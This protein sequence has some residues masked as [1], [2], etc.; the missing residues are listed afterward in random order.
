MNKNWKNKL[1]MTIKRIWKYALSA[2]LML[3]IIVAYL[4]FTRAP[5]IAKAA[6]W[7]DSWSYRKAIVIN[8]EQVTGDLTNFPVLVSL[9]DENLGNHAQD[10]GD[11]IIFISSNGQKLSHEIENY[12]STTGTLVTWVK[13]PSLSSDD[14]TVIYMYYGN[15]MVENQQAIENVWDDNYVGVWHMADSL[16]ASTS[17]SIGNSANGSAIGTASTTALGKIDGAFQFDG[18]SDSIDIPD[19]SVFDFDVN[20]DYTWSFWIKPEVFAAYSTI[21]SQYF[22]GDEFFMIYAHTCPTGTANC[23]YWGPV[24]N[25][26]T[27][28]W[29]T[30][31]GNSLYAHSTNNVLATSTF[32][33]VSITYDSSQLQP[34]R[35][36]IYIDGQDVTDNGDVHNAGT[37]RSVNPVSIMLGDNAG[38][39]EYFDGSIDEVRFSNTLRSSDWIQTS[40]NNQANVSAFA[41]D[42]SEETGPGPVAYWTFNEGYGSIAHDES[43]QG[44]N[45]TIT[46]ATWQDESM[47]VSGKCVG[48]DIHRDDYIEIENNNMINNSAGT[49]GA[50]INKRASTSRS[51]VYQDIGVYDK[52]L[53]LWEMDGDWTDT[54]GNYDGTASGTPQATTTNKKIGSG[55]GYFNGTEPTSIELPQESDF[56]FATGNFSISAWVLPSSASLGATE[57]IVSKAEVSSY[58]LSINSSEI[59]QFRAYDGGGYETADSNSAIE[60]RRWYHLVGV[61]RGSGSGA[62]VELYIDGV[63]QDTVATMDAALTTNNYP[64]VIG[65]DGGYNDYN[66]DGYIDEVAIFNEPLTDEE[67]RKL[68]ESGNNYYN[69]DSVISVSSPTLNDNLISLWKFD[70]DTTDFQENIDGTVSGTITYSTA[71]SVSGYAIEF[72]GSSYITIGNNTNEPD[73]DFSISAWAYPTVAGTN[74]YIA[75]NAESAGYYLRRASTNKFQW[76]PNDGGGYETVASNNTASINTW[77]HVVGV[78]RGSGAGAAVELYVNGVKQDETAIMDANMSKSSYPF[79]IGVN[80]GTSYVEYFTGFIDEVAFYDR[81]LTDEEVRS[82]YYRGEM[83]IYESNNEIIFS[84][85][86]SSSIS[87][88]ISYWKSNEWHYVAG[89]YDSGTYQIFIDG[90]EK[91]SGSYYEDFSIAGNLFIGRGWEDYRKFGFGGRIDEVK[92]Y[93]YARTVDEIRQDYNSGKA[94]VKTSKGVSAAFG[95]SSDSWM[96]DGLVGYWKMDESA[97]TSGAIDSSG[98]GN[99]GAYYGDA[100]TTAGKYGNGFIGDGNGDYIDIGTSNFNISSTN[101]YS[102]ALWIKI[103]EDLDGTRGVLR[104]GQYIYP[105]SIHLSIA[106]VLILGTRTNNGVSYLNANNPLSLDTWYYIVSTFKNGERVMYI[107]GVIENTDN[108]SGTLDIGAY[109]THIGN[110]PNSSNQEFPGQIDEVRIYNRALSAGEVRKLYEWAPGPVLY[111]KLDEKEG[112]SAYDRSGNENEGILEEL[113]I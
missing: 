5:E 46:G 40:Y 81:P 59:V 84:I 33:Y 6:W 67:V 110:I 44:N 23:T 95:A 107:D 53:G 32:H 78:V 82:L 58:V 47:C 85:G 71:T 106:E 103:D 88:D 9:T 7:N 86:T 92:Y 29:E 48:F 49:F 2:I 109:S 93:P 104:R 10:D 60:V 3:S 76:G 25:G 68:Y 113:S 98:N 74:M 69:K 21:W 36:T 72:D 27:A 97:T 50:W 102:I 112:S 37:I 61:L 13:I 17:D 11:D 63:K 101:E 22:D 64:L 20:T 83:N 62:T 31:T 41:I 89:S 42:Q 57:A 96:S 55:S 18:D 75:G 8:H 100:S 73:G 51:Q 34:D 35:F 30:V 4:Y 52:L 38:W 43:G 1:N 70:N 15:T 14:D 111:W 19:S 24:E 54:L 56:D 39:D 66:F 65:A 80:P 94:G 99:N 26:I 79:C 105:F 28:G 12:A 90:I 87:A 45:G 16:T 91:V 108:I 77:Y